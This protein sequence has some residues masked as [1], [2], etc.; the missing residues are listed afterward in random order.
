MGCASH[1]VLCPSCNDSIVAG[2]AGFNLL[3]S[4]E[5]PSFCLLL[6]DELWRVRTW[7]D[8]LHWPTMGEASSSHLV[9]GMQQ[10]VCLAGG[11][12]ERDWP[13]VLITQLGKYPCFLTAG[14]SSWEGL[15][16]GFVLT[17]STCEG[18]QMSVNIYIAS[19]TG[20]QCALALSECSWPAEDE[21]SSF[22][23]PSNCFC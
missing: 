18:V 16:G 23:F 17:T 22:C 3:I 15:S 12:G 13:S 21:R 9:P 11:G 7:T 1:P 6:V 14:P 10:D 8:E 2:W 20:L 4:S 5:L 19:V